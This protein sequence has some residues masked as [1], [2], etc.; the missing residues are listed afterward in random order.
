[1]NFKFCAAVVGF[2][3]ACLSIGS[4]RAE[5]NK[6]LYELQERCGKQAR[7]T[8]R[9]GWG[10]HVVNSTGWQT[11]ANFENHYNVRLDKCFYIEMSTTY[12]PKTKH[13]KANEHFRLFDLNEN[14]EYAT[15][16]HTEGLPLLCYVGDRG[17]TTKEEWR[18]LVKPFMEE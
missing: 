16:D 17:C 14:K 15:Y 1:M 10:G 9:S 2:A 11:I 13:D 3:T 12:P 18:A 8:F 7:E 5:P 4:V 6:V